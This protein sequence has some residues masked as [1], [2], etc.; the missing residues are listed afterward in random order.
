MDIRPTMTAYNATRSDT[1]LVAG[2]R[3]R[4]IYLVHAEFQQIFGY[5]SH[6]LR[7]NINNH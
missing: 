1:V 7:L 4:Y 6:L 3:A 5:E 2:R